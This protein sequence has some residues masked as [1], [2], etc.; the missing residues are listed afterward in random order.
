M[1]ARPLHEVFLRRAQGIGHM[2]RGRVLG[3]DGFQGGES[4]EVILL[5]SD[6][7][8]PLLRFCRKTH[9][10]ATIE[11]SEIRPAGLSDVIFGDE[12]ILK[13]EQ[14]GS[15]SEIIDN[16]RGVAEVEVKFRDLFSKS[17]SQ[18]KEKSAGT[19]VSV[20][21]EASQSIEGIAEFKE[22]L[23]TEAHA[24]I[25]ESEGSETTREEE[26]EEGS[27]V[28]VGKRVRIIETRE[29]ADGEI[30]VTAKG[31]F[32][33]QVTVGRYHHG[34]FITVRGAHWD[35]FDKFCDVVTGHAP[36]NWDLAKSFKDHGAYHA[37]MWALDP[38]N[39]E[40]R[41][42]VKFE[43]RIVRNYTVEEF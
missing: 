10:Q 12:H 15:I 9:D 28:P 42:T 6:D 32:N 16:R 8:V 26:G 33:H 7:G 37:D 17:E 3:L 14:V 4:L 13:S 19:S 34:R 23:E 1:N 22:T 41:Y 40:L 39:S 11:F 20:S 25:T 5:S 27:S 36:D 35:S 24:E 38:L 43:G 30:D 31:K 18:E 29:R 2:L 21:V